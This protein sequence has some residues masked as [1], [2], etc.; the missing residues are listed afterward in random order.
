M[1]MS[2][3]TISWSIFLKKEE[4]RASCFGARGKESTCQCRRCKRCGFD[5]W[6]GKIP[7]IRKWQST[8]VFLPGKFHGQRS[9][10]SY[11]PWRHRESDMTEQLNTHIH[12][13][14]SILCYLFSW[15]FFFFSW[16]DILKGMN[17]NKPSFLKSK[18]FVEAG[19][20]KSLGNG[21]S[22]GKRGTF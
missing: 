15:S 17:P 7:W 11:S 16:M 14:K 21:G 19:D 18:P 9:L 22:W 6:V 3:G 5:P 13:G 1:E 12:I 2:Q 4:N 8:L 10:A 20:R